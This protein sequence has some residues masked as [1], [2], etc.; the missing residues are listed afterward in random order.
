MFCLISGTVTNVKLINDRVEPS[1]YKI[2]VTPDLPES[3]V[4]QVDTII[5]S[6]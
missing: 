5:V 6:V 3:T 2:S 1:E 4:I